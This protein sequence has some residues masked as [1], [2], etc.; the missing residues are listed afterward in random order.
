MSKDSLNENDL[1]NAVKKGDNKAFEKLFDLYWEVVY[2]TAF[3]YIKDES[4]CQDI[5]QDI[6]LTIWEKREHLN[7]DHLSS[8]LKAS[9]R[10]YIYRYNAKKKRNQ[11]E[12]LNEEYVGAKYQSLNRGEQDVLYDES[13]DSLKKSLV[14][15]PRRCQEVF[16]LSRQEELTNQEIAEQL[17]IS[18]RTV[19]N[20]ITIALRHLKINL[21]KIMS[22]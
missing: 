17:N 3:T 21:N 6:F 20:Q 1:W 19:E 16:L 8:Y 13:Y 2:K 4:V 18:K 12:E 10:Y 5:T 15:L 7:I 14:S 22:K 11:I 9:T